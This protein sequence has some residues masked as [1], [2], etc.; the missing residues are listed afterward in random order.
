VSDDGREEYIR[1]PGPDYVPPPIDELKTRRESTEKR[2]AA[3][4][5]AALAERG[6]RYDVEAGEWRR[7]PVGES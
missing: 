5:R 2:G 1:G 6:I 7:D 3:L 4:V